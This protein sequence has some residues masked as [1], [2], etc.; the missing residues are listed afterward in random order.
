M[1]GASAN[2][3]TILTDG[4]AKDTWHVYFDGTIIP[5]AQ[6]SSFIVLKH[7]YAKGNYN[8]YYYGKRID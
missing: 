1:E 8:T 3:F 5:D 6:A 7:G 4:F 2:S